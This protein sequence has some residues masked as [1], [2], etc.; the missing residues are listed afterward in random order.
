MD[1]GP[2]NISLERN[3]IIEIRKAVTRGIV[4]SN[5]KADDTHNPLDRQLEVYTYIK[6]SDIDSSLTGIAKLRVQCRLS[7][8]DGTISLRTIDKNFNAG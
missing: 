8:H 1:A 3:I 5:Y 4:I 2:L 7:L 6:L